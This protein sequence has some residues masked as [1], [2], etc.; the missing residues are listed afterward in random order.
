[1]N[2]YKNGK[3]YKI[4]SQNTDMFYIGSTTKVLLKTRMNEHRHAFKNEYGKMDSCV[5]FLWDD[6]E[7]KLIEDYPCESKTELRK[8]E[9]Y[10]MDLFP[11]YIVNKRRAYTNKKE[12]DRLYMRKRREEGTI[13]QREDNKEYMKEYYKKNK[14]KAR[15]KGKQYRQDYAAE[16]AERDRKYKQSEIGKAKRKANDKIKKLCECCNKLISKGNFHTHKKTKIHLENMR[17]LNS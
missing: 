5:M 3:I 14:E 2:K 15:E 1:M 7:I 10:Y 9:Q 8:R 16:K 11:D 4:I 17:K 13:K 12:K 6:A